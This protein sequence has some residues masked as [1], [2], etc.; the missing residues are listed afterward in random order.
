MAELKEII[1]FLEDRF[2]PSFAEDFD[3][4]GLLAGRSNKN[5]FKVLLCLDF[6]KEVCEEAVNFG[7]DLII[8]HHPVIFSPLKRIS[9]KT[10]KEKAI[11]YAIE[12]KISIYSAHTNLDSAEGGLT[13][14]IVKM[15]SL[16][17]FSAL[18]GNL[19]RLCTAPGG[20]T[21]KKLVK[22]IKEVF[23]LDKIYS[24]LTE[25]KAVNTIAI[26]NGGGG[27]ELVDAV[28]RL[29]ADIYISGDLKHHE[30][31]EFKQS[32]TDYIEIR[33]HD[34]EFVVTSL[35]KEVLEKKFGASLEVMISKSDTP[36][37]IDTD[38][39]I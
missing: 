17:S 11:L 31:L 39:I 18:E 38:K 37:L 4:I 3:N 34:C 2:P 36:S 16:S 12:N 22:K 35:L 26:C 10:N 19:G 25:D 27:G 6:T 14:Y 5:V 9:D 8:T 21:A 30:I 13:D 7:A 28:Q 23:N 15:L 32:T 29:N 1:N 33:H 24:T 20:T